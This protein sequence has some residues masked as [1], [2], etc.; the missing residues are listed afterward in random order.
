MSQLSS[1]FVV[2][3]AAMAEKAIVRIETQ[4][5]ARFIVRDLR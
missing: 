2:V 1:L 3:G 5:R 4:R